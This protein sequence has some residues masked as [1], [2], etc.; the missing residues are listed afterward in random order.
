MSGNITNNNR[1]ILNA[2]STVTGLPE[3]LSSTAHILNVNATVSLA[4]NSSINVAQIAGT[5]TSVGNGTTD[6]GT[7]R[8]TIS[9]DSTGQVKL[10]TG[11]NV[12]GSIS[13][14][15]FAVT[16]STSPWVVSLASTTITGT[17]AVTQ[18][19][20][21][22]VVAG[23]GSA[24]TAATGVVTV[25]GITSMTPL[26]VTP[27]ANSA[28]NLAQIAGT[29]VDTNSGAKSAGT[30]RIVVATDQLALTTAG[31]FSVKI[32]QTTGGTTNAVSLAQLGANA[33]A[34]DNGASSTGTQRVTIANNS[35]GVL[36]SIGSITGSIVPGTAATNLGK[37]EDA[38]HASGD[39]GI[40]AWGVRND[41]LATTYGADQ[42]YAPFATDANGRTM[43]AQKA[44][45]GTLSNVASS[46]TSV[47]V[48]AANSARIGATITND[49]SALLY[50][51]FGTTASTTSY[52]VV[53]AGAASAPFSYYEVPAGYTGRIDGIW[54]S[55]SGNARVTEIT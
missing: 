31:V 43:V 22:W 13:N 49:S 23:G 53:L 52:T 12:I 24:G 27:A 7:Q 18:S 2:R 38:A 28:I 26:L 3:Y 45:T 46:A 15:S 51:K 40:A 19:T 33:I 29:T 25:Q 1:E 5:T 8:V 14:T 34:V 39:T 44:A 9:S 55:A 6:A 47:T 50:V 11:A 16:Q 48:L 17:V 21:P 30:Q 35:T 54:A 37:A 10:A 41:N 36:A 4:P 20:T 42:D 32:D